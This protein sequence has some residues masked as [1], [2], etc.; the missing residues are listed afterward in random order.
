MLLQ[1][2]RH[3]CCTRRSTKSLTFESR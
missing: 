1:M 2:L 3:C